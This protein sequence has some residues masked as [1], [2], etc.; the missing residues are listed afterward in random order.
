MEGVTLGEPMSQVRETLGNPAQVLPVGERQ[1]W[2]YV[3]HNGSVFVDVIPEND[4]VISVTVI[5]RVESSTYVDDRGVAFGM[6]SGDV[7]AKLGAATKQ[8]TNSDDGSVDL[9]YLEGD[10]S[11]IYEFYGDKLGFLQIVARPGSQL[12]RS[13]GVP[14]MQASPSPAPSAS[15]TPS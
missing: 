3:E 1:M 14:Q 4:I 5:R 12:R 13:T 7:Q 9:W 8:S 2:R 10:V 6:S 11:R 15:P